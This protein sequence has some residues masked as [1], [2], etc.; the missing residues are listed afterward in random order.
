MKL[1]LLAVLA[2]VL[3][4]AQANA[5]YCYTCNWEQSN[6]RCLKAEK[7]SDEDEFCVTNVAS[8]GIGSLSIW[9]RITKK[10]SST[11]PHHNFLLGLITYTSYC[12]QSFLC[13][14]TACPGP[15]L[16]RP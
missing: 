5:L 11:C 2:L 6:W 15:R 12:C 7:C 9:K 4:A 8:V 3:F 16:A 14:L 13:N 1:F 10:C